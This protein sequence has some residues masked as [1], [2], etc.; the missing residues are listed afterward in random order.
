MYGGEMNDG[1]LQGV[2]LELL[3][4]PYT[5]SGVGPA[6]AIAMGHKGVCRMA[7]MKDSGVTC[8]QAGAVISLEEYKKKGGWSYP[9]HVVKPVT[10]GPGSIGISFVESDDE[11]HKVIS[12]WSYGAKNF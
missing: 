1:T 4:I 3:G 10:E 8:P 2:M 5:F 7:A 6:S 9:P 12:N 11:R